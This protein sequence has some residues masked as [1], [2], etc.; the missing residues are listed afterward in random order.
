MTQDEKELYKDAIKRGLVTFV[1]RNAKNLRDQYPELKDKELYPELAALT[2]QDMMFVFLFR[3]DCSP[4]YNKEDR[5]KLDVCIDMAYKSEQV[6]SQK[7]RDWANLDFK[8]PF[9]AAFARMATFN[10]SARIVNYQATMVLRR[11]C[12]AIINEDITGMDSDEK[13]AY[14][15]RAAAAQK[16]M[17]DTMKDLEAGSFGV[18]EYDNTIL[19]TLVGSLADERNEN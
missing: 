4:F 5:D 15:K 17:K 12:L 10:N 16:A 3:A 7:R 19:S 18:E 13:D 9:P 14:I 8:S 1:P 11:N 6:R 2:Q